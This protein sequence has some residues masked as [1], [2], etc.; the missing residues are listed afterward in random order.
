MD[1]N[2]T[3]QEHKQDT[4]A[5]SVKNKWT[6]KWQGLILSNFKYYSTVKIIYIYSV[7]FESSDFMFNFYMRW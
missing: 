6:S 1:H 2:T 4:L 3:I 7:A 5:N